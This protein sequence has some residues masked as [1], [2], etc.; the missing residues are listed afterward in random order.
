MSVSQLDFRVIPIHVSK[1]YALLRLVHEDIGRL[2]DIP[3]EV[4]IL[5]T[6]LPTSPSAQDVSIEQ[7]EKIRIEGA[8]F[9]ALWIGHL[10]LVYSSSLLRSRALQDV[11]CFGSHLSQ[12]SLTTTLALVL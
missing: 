11:R 2:G 3:H 1:G 5:G 10:V 4:M 9:S 8:A 12:S 6:S 7:G